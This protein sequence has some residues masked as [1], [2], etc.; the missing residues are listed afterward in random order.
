MTVL[1]IN[2]TQNW[3]CHG[4]STY[5]NTHFDTEYNIDN[6]TGFGVPYNATYFI[7]D[8]SSLPTG[9]VISSAIWYNKCNYWNTDAPNNSNILIQRTT[10]IFTS[11]ITFNSYNGTNGWTTPGGDVTTDYQATHPC[12]ALYGWADTNITDMVKYARDNTSKILYMR[13]SGDNSAGRIAVGY[14]T[15]NDATEANRPYLEITYSLP[16]APQILMF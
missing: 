12:P 5:V 8:F 9:V 14:Y 10:R 11:G 4:Y 7:L 13:H 3:Y 2:P 15:Y 6:Y 16:S 1:R